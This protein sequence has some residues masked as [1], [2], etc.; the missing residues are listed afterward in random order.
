MQ[1]LWH[2]VFR[3]NSVNAIVPKSA[4]L[5][6]V[7]LMPNAGQSNMHGKK[8]VAGEFFSARG[9]RRWIGAWPGL[10]R[11]MEQH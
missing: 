1:S 9:G 11:S 6:L 3:T 8:V 5:R 2:R 7:K 10:A 4:R